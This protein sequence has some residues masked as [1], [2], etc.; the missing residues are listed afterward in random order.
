[1]E[2]TSLELFGHPFAQCFTLSENYRLQNEMRNDACLAY[3][4]SGQQE[5]FSATKKLV[6]KDRES[7]L[8]KCGNYIANFAD[9][10]PT[11]QFKSIVFHLDPESIRKS[12]G[13][14]DLNFLRVEHSKKAMDPALKIGQN[15]VLDA[16]VNGMVPYFDHPELATEELL[17]LKLQELV[18]ILSDSGKN[19]IATYILGTLYTPEQVAFDEIVQANLYNNLSIAELAH[20]TAKSESTF[21][22]EFRKIYD[23]SPAKYIKTKR[24][25]KAAE[26]LKNSSLQVSEVAWDAGFENPAHFSASFHKHFGQS[27]KEFRVQAG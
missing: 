23:E 2:M 10:T 4:Q 15:E 17:R 3:V 27:P 18:L 20:L 5:I 1:M 25:E 11:S 7:I 14:R 13:D 6:A 21:K 24:L 22:R 8:M 26:L 19:P 9:V 12:F 16:F